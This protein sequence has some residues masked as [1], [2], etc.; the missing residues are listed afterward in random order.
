MA[1]QA[2][3]LLVSPSRVPL[4]TS[5]VTTRSALLCFIGGRSVGGCRE[6]GKSP[7]L[8]NVVATQRDVLDLPLITVVII[9]RIGIDEVEVLAWNRN[10]RLDWEFRLLLVGLLELRQASK[11]FLLFC[12]QASFSPLSRET[13]RPYVV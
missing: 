10:G 9:L 4:R 12:S 11:R 5:L 2:A 6:V 1:G 13:A 8:S 7:R 3:L